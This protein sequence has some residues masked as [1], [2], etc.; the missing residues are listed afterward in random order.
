MSFFGAYFNLPEGSL[1][2]P[3]CCPFPHECSDGTTYLEHRPSAHVNM[4]KLVFNCKACDR[5]Y[6]IP[7]FINTIVGGDKESQEKVRKLFDQE[8]Q[9]IGD[10]E[11]STVLTEDSHKKALSLG[12]AED[13]IKQLKI[14]TPDNEP[15]T[16]AFPVF[17][18][19]RI[20][21]VRRY[22]P[23]GT[24]KIK[25]MNG[26]TSGLIIPFDIWRESRNEITT[27]ICAGEKDMAVA[28]SHGFNAITITGGERALPKFVN[29]FRNRPV[30][31]VY[32]NDEAGKQGAEK[33]ATFLYPYAKQVKVV[34]GFHEI[35][36]EKGEDI[37]D[38]FTKYNKTRDDLIDYIK[39]TPV[40]QLKSPDL[41]PTKRPTVDLYEA[42]QKYVGRIVNSN[43]QV[44]AVS[45][46][47][48]RVPTEIMGV[49]TRHTSDTE[50]SMK[51]D[52][53][54]YWTLDESNCESIMYLIDSN[55]KEAQIFD[56]IRKYIFKKPN[57]RCLH[58]TTLQ[59]QTV[60]K[61]TLTDLFETVDKDVQPMEYTAYSLG[62]KLESGKKY[63]ISYKL[64]PHPLKGQQL[65]M[66]ILNA[67]QASDS[68]SSF[69]LDAKTINNLKQIQNLEPTVEKKIETLTEMN[70]AFVGYDGINE[71]IKTIDLS[72]N[73]P[74]RFHFGRVKNIRGYLDT[75]IVGESRTGK[76]STA[77]ALRK[78]Y[79]LGTFTS[80]AGNSATIAGLIGGSSKSTSGSMQTRAGV[81]PQN[82]TGLIIFEEFGKSN[83][84]VLKELTDIRSSNEVRIARVS[85]TTTLPALVR[86]IALT[87]VKTT[88]EIRSIASYPN[89]ISIVTELV[90]TA[91]DIARYDVILVLSEAGQTDID[92]LWEP[93]KPLDEQCYRDRIRWI[94][95]RTPEQ[96]VISK[97]LEKYIIEKSNE[98]NKIYPSHIKLFGTE[99]WKKIARV[100][101]AVAGYTVSASSDYKQIIVTKECIDYAVK[102]LIGLYDN[103]TFKFKEYVDMELRYRTTDDEATASLQ[104]IFNKYSGLVLQLEQQREI[105]KAMLESTT[106]LEQQEIRKGLQLLTRSYFIKVDNTTITPTER[107]RLT[108]N[109]INKGTIVGRI[110]EI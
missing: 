52:E 7:G 81:I 59:E 12:I 68:L 13:V 15:D 72:F 94:W 54:I 64:A 10:W 29:Y 104:L 93:I 89:G 2:N 30:A 6:S 8:L 110:G 107:F 21:D 28:R 73:T 69:T 32:D 97:D 86:M 65:T 55:L 9:T 82:H 102:Y 95:T 103:D 40:Y 101:V 105:T 11:T 22:N 51:K 83:K 58:P 57:E 18:Y 67:T 16:L 108:I 46:T 80:L 74:L 56:N 33:L 43:I 60:Y 14:R 87:N 66:I 84:D 90:S 44:V 31:I 62:H 50:S 47:A 53:R 85:G 78:L 34:T 45:E 19:D 26:T 49:K 1:E 98:L 20:V 63:A 38:F 88:G 27:V 70:K 61:I 37:T 39:K 96:I 91:E 36:K 106:G 17:A 25:S 24:P 99:A 23:G 71:L 92:P 100:A 5:S 77:D 35:C 41:D 48:F 75:L 109:K 76:S 79:G 42:S 3:V 4:T